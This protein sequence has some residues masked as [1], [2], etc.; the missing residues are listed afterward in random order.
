VTDFDAAAR[1]WDDD[2]TKARRARRVAEAIVGRGLPLGGMTVLEYG[3]GTGLLGFALAPHVAHVT[4]ADTSPGM[5]AV[6]RDKIAASGA[7][8]VEAR[9]VDLV[10]GHTLYARYD[11]VCTLMTL[12]H[13]TDTDEILRNVHDVLAAGGRVC[14]SDLDKEDGAFH[15]VGF[16]GHNGFDREDLARRLRQAGFVNP[17]FT[18]IDEITKHTDRGLR[19]FPL[20]LAVARK[21]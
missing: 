7:R 1:T 6:V 17:E 8:N 19:T 18:T 14:I 4:L 21:A 16:T 10:K 20:F 15:G 11:L 5:L 12:H 2:P 9:H 13:I 3:C